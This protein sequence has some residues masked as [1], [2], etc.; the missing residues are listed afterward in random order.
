MTA[1]KR[2]PFVRVETRGCETD[3]RMQPDKLAVDF[4][5]ASMTA[6]DLCAHGPGIAEVILTRAAAPGT[7]TD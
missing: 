6:L 3:L 4:T 1:T 2:L 7:V 5:M